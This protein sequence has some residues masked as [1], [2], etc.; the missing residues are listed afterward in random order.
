MTDND[1][2]NM[3]IVVTSIY[4]GIFI[5]LTLFKRKFKE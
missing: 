3:L 1:L 4:L 2:T 5:A